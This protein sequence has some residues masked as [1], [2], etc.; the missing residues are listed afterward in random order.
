MSLYICEY[1]VNKDTEKE[2]LFNAKLIMNAPNML[3]TLRNV[4]NGLYALRD[5]AQNENPIFGQVEQKLI[6][7]IIECIKRIEK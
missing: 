3:E 2:D 5:V 1:Y 7:E 6:N 4:A